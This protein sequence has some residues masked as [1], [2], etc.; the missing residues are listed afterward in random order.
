MSR[1]SSTTLSVTAVLTLGV[2]FLPAVDEVPSV[3]QRL[4]ALDQE[5]KILQRKAELVAEEAAASDNAAKKAPKFTANNKDG[6]S[7][8]SSDGAY[9]LRFG[10]S[11]Q[12]EGVYFLNDD[13]VPKNNTFFV[14]RVR[15]YFQGTVAKYFDYQLV[16]DYS[17]LSTTTVSLL[18]A[19]VT[20]NI[21]PTFK[22][23][24]GRFKTPFG[25]EYLQA[26]PQTAFIERGFPTQLSPGRDAG[27]Q[28][29]GEIGGGLVSY[30]IG[31]FNGPTDRADR[32]SDSSDDKEAIARLYAAPF[33]ESNLVALAGLNV[34][35]AVSYGQDAPVRNAANTTITASNLPTYQSP[36]GTTFF[37]YAATAVSDGERLRFSPQLYYTW[38]SWDVLAE[39]VSSRQEVRTAN[40]ATG[41]ALTERIGV[42][43]TAWQIESGYVLTG[44]DSGFRGISPDGGGVGASGWGAVQL[45]LRVS[46][47]DIDNAAFSNGLASR[48]TSAEQALN[49]GVGVNWW[50]NRNVR[51]ALNYDRTEFVAGGGGTNANP[52]DK[53]TEQIIRS[54]VQLIF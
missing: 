10:G 38:G 24:A 54:R 21:D 39:Y 47:F 51:I 23:Q 1:F 27:A 44:E 49:C 31:I 15:P 52:I 30:Q 33:K 22:L 5:I 20:A 17:P 42:T 32:D 16:L 36:G 50:L 25:L 13:A 18:D 2:H 35:I 7:L 41:A 46:E 3:E 4:Q 34:G 43:H 28:A 37:S 48:T 9:K 8:S 11:A 12:I 14:R 26:D 6:F 45:V 53:E 29:L 19:S 40:F